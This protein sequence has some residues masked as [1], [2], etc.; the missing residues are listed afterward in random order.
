[1]GTATPKHIPNFRWFDGIFSCLSYIEPTKKWKF[2][3]LTDC[4]RQHAVYRWNRK[5][6]SGPHCEGCGAPYEHMGR[7]W[8]VVPEFYY[9]FGGSLEDFVLEYL[10]IRDI[11]YSPYEVVLLD[12]ELMGLVADSLERQ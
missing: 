12:N 8:K 11:D 2:Q 9:E 7:S 6:V 5:K 1:M 10:T 4:C 3:A